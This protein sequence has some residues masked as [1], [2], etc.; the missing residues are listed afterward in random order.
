MFGN[1]QVNKMDRFRPL[2]I[3]S[4]NLYTHYYSTPL[5]L[6]IMFFK[7]AILAALS[8]S[9]VLGHAV[10]KTPTPRTVRDFFRL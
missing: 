6:P 9:Q 5:S 10:V 3:I 4:F 2:V 1:R 7:P 8:V